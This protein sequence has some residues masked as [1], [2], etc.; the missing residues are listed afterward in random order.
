MMLIVD[1][2]IKEM[3]NRFR[4]ENP[5]P[6]TEL[7]YINNYT[8]LVAIMLSAQTTDKQVNKVTSKLFKILQSPK[9]TIKIGIEK[10]EE[11]ISSI[12]LWRNKARNIVAMSQ[13]LIDKFNNT[14]PN[15]MEQLITLPGVGRKSA[16]AFLITAFNLPMMPVDTHVFRVSNR[17]G[18][19]ST[20]NVKTTEQ[21]L[22][23]IIP[24]KDMANTHNWLV[25]HGRYTCKALKP[26]CNKCLISDLCAFNQ[27]QNS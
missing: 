26:R 12:G 9:D 23:K 17:I 22:L 18:I 4:K 15:N 2:I 7:D 6:T 16:N 21:E 20:N 14:I 13:I 3:L 10:L 8:L 11:H 1:M 19:V 24:K 25:L 27:T 5:N